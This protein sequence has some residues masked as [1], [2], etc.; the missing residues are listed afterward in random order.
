MSPEEIACENHFVSTHLREMNGRFSVRLPLRHD[1]SFLGMMV[2]M[3][4]D[5]LP[6]MLWSLGRIQEVHPGRTILYELL[7]LK[8]LKLLQQMVQHFWT[9][10]SREYLSGLQERT[11]WKR[12]F[13][14]KLQ[15]GVMVVLKD[16]NAPP[17]LWKLERVTDAHPGQDGVIKVV[18]VKTCNGVVR[19][20]VNK[21]CMIPLDSKETHET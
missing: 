15:P 1:I 17:L 4:E 3:V 7:Q 19:R 12:N 11:K 8:L 2:I 13:N 20:A 21:V 16:D 6:P 9:R 10:W 5:N 18:S 14:T